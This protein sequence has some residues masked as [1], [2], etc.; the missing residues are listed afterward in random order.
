MN[1]KDISHELFIIVFSSSSISSV[2]KIRMKIYIINSVLVKLQEKL[3]R[4]KI[5]SVK[6]YFWNS[7][8]INFVDKRVQQTCRKWKKL[9]FE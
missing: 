8:R 5:E 2:S 7:D 9:Y 3:I 4:P 1:F 6:D